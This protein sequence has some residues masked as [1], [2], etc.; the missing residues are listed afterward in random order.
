M[1]QHCPLLKSLIIRDNLKRRQDHVGGLEMV[2]TD[3][4]PVMRRLNKDNVMKIAR[5][6]GSENFVCKAHDTHTRNS[7]ET[8][9]RNLYVCHTDLHKIFLTRV[10]RIK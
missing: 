3:E 5:Y 7:Y 10:S 6:R 4:D 2:T 1:G 9:A 8:R